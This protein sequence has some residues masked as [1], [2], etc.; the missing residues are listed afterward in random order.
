MN[1]KIIVGWLV[2][3]VGLLIIGGAISSS[4]NFFTAKAD[5]PAIFKSTTVNNQVV[6]QIKPAADVSG[7]QAQIQQMMSQATNNAIA[8]L[9]PIESIYKILNAI[10]WSIFAT[11][12]VYAGFKIAEIGVKMIS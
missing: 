4:Y 3:T 12:L 9:F 1:P 2:L 6:E 5:F 7:P 11:F 10:T 8:N